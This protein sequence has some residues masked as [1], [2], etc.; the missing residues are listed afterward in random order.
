MGDGSQTSSF[1]DYFD[2]KEFKKVIQSFEEFV[3]QFE[4]ML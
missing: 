1:E 2:E 4:R 3:D